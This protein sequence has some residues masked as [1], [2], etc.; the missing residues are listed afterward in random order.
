MPYKNPL[1]LAEAIQQGE[2]Q[3]TPKEFKDVTT[4]YSNVPGRKVYRF[5]DGDYTGT[6][7]V[8]DFP[9]ERNI[10]EGRTSSINAYFKNKP[11]NEYTENG[12]HKEFLDKLL[13]FLDSYGLD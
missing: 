6:D 8:W 7:R 11:I 10:N 13:T 2:P 3:W 1:D 12:I 5:S 4:A 9:N